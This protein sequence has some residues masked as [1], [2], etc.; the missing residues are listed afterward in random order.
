MKSGF[1]LNIDFQELKELDPKEVWT[2]PFIPRMLIV[3]C[4]TI[5]VVLAGYFTLIS[6]QYSKLS[7]AEATMLK[8]KTD[9]M[10]KTEQALNIEAYKVQRDSMVTLF[11][12]LLKQLPNK[13]EIDGLLNDINQAGVGRGLTFDLFKPADKE[14]LYEFYAELPISIRLSGKYH[15]FGDF[16]SAVANLTRIVT[17][18]D[19][20]IKSDT[21]NGLVLDATAKT[22]R[23]L[24]EKEVQEQKK[25]A[26][27]EKAKNKKGA[28]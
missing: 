4:F 11:S 20:N 25:I 22:F 15:D 19:L 1:K 13:A 5:L 27:A 7:S 23:Y 26:A 16:S 9:Y 8:L 24:D 10:E 14:T 3:C 28:K 21:K 12:E 18:N 17:I 2:W 6:E